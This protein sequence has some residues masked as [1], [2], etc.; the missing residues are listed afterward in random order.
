MMT[1][2]LSPV[3]SFRNRTDLY[4]L[5]GIVRPTGRGA[6]HAPR[7]EA[8]R[9]YT[10]TRIRPSPSPQ[11]GAALLLLLCLLTLGSLAWFVRQATDFNPAATRNVLTDR[12]L[13]EAKEALLGYAAA[14]P[15]LH[16]KGTP[17]RAI[18]VPGHLPCPDTDNALG[19]EGA[20]AGTCGSAGVTVIGHFPWRSLGIPPP[21]DG[22]GECLWY[23]V[24]GNYKANPKAHLLNPD[25]PGQFQIL[26][27]EGNVRVGATAADRPVA[28]LF[29]PGPPLAGQSRQYRSG[30]CRRDYDAQQFLDALNGIDNAS[31]NTA[32]EE[33]TRLVAAQA[34]E[35]FNDRLLWIGRAELFERRIARRPHPEQ[36]LFDGD[37]PGDK[38]ALTQRVAA[39][40][41]R[42]GDGNVWHRLPWAAPLNLSAAAPDT[43]QNDKFADKK[44]LR[45]G[46]PPFLVTQSETTLKSEQG[47]LKDCASGNAACR[48]LR[49]DNCPELL[50]V[51]GTGEANSKDGWFDKWKDHL[52]YVVAPG[53]APAVAPAADCA[54]EPEQCL[55]VNGRSYAAALIFSGAPLAGQPR[56]T[57]A[58][59][60]NADHYLE[61]ENALSVKNNGRILETAGNDQIVCLSGPD[62]TTSG[63]TLVP[64][65]GQP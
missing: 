58:D 25:I 18:F 64:D 47:T 59:R 31:P 23:A 39:C 65:C 11:S 14:Y 24:S 3:I 53:F 49:S 50:P 13:A 56:D 51:A 2:P 46:R 44:D 9:P 16:L 38:I 17:E 7:A 4:G 45:A 30:E 36:D 48:W 21:R 19:N 42:F 35:H 26:D 41:A 54:L 62:A 28:V 37:Y 29:A 8:I 1:R 52:F 20:E 34:G 6:L 55:R 22:A 40:L 61:G 63:F 43:F 12:A 10:L 33:V 5:I 60:Q 57:S 27:A 15:E 32:P